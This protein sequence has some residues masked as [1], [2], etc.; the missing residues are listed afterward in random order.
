M[1]SNTKSKRHMVLLV[2]MSGP[3]G[4]NCSCCFPQSGKGRKPYV[5]RVKNQQRLQFKKDLKEER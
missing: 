2:A 1:Q 4:V 5:R 3:G